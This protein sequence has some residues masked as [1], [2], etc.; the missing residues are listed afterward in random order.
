MTFLV[1]DGVTPSNEGRGYVLRRIIRRAVLHGR[2]L[3]LESFLPRLSGVVVGQMGSVYPELRE[4][5]A[6][7]GELLAAEEERFSRTLALGERY[8]EEAA[9]D[10]A[11]SGEE[12]FKL[13]DTYGYPIE[14]TRERAGERGLAVDEKGFERLM[15]EQ[16]ERSRAAAAF[17]VDIKVAGGQP[18]EF[19]G[20]E[21]TEVLTAL[22]ALEEFE[23][24][25]FQAKL[26]ESPFYPEGGGQ[27]SDVGWIEK[28]D[29]SV[30]AELVKATRV[31]DDQVLTF[32]GGGSRP[33][34]G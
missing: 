5:K 11:I 2:D 6:I 24:G 33:A 13:H 28:V 26:Y 4:K 31:G 17:D 12:A 14:L 18:T 16:R 34:T 32:R 9:A 8:F 20:Y 25:L 10:R 19:V 27:V 21:K 15:A 22:M 30:H 1:A 7:I 3:G 23:D 29:G